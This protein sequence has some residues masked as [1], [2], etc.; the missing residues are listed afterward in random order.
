MLRVYD[1]LAKLGKLG[2]GVPRSLEL[3]PRSCPKH[4][5]R[6]HPQRRSIRS[7]RPPSRGS[8]GT[9]RRRIRRPGF[10][11]LPARSADDFRIVAERVASVAATASA[12]SRRSRAGS[13]S[14]RSLPASRPGC[15][16]PATSVTPQTLRSRRPG[17]TGLRPRP[18]GGP[19]HDLGCAGDS[20]RCGIAPA[21]EPA[22]QVPSVAGHLGVSRHR[23]VVTE[24][25]ASRSQLR[26]EVGEV[27]VMR[28]SSRT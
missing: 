2:V 8:C 24:L 4:A 14:R 11:S 10:G 16:R 27:P 12:S 22:V 26:P 20:Q 17:A 7:G 13:S 25:A 21:P 5:H 9:R 15:G 1:C 6:P 3:V 19:C 28:P 18:A 23:W